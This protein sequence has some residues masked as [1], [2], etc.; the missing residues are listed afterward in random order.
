MQNDDVEIPGNDEMTLALA[1]FM[2]WVNIR[3]MANPWPPDDSRS[4]IGENPE[5]SPGDDGVLVWE[6]LDFDSDFYKLRD[7]LLSH[8]YAADVEYSPLGVNVLLAHDSGA[9]GSSFCEFG[10]DADLQALDRRAWTEA[11]YVALTR[12]R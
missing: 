4:W 12:A 7:W 3:E 1:R 2:G 11:A 5:M 8:G 9:W 6:P 10:D